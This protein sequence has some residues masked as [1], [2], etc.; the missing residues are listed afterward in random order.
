M[1]RPLLVALLA[2]FAASLPAGA[3][4][5]PASGTLQAAVTAGFD[6][7]LSNADGTPV[8]HLDPGSYVINVDDSTN[9]HNF[10]LNGPGLNMSTTVGEVVMTQWT[11]ELKDGTY[12]FQCD[13]HPG[14]MRGAFTVGTP[15][16]VPRLNAK[17]TAR[18]ISLKD[19]A[20]VRVRTLPQ[21]TYKIAVSDTAK[22]QNFHLSGP[23]VNR[24]TKV[25]ARTKTTW[26]VTLRPGTYVYR[27]DKNRKL[28]RAFIVSSGPPP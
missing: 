4:S 18:A 21:N 14:T 7:S 5:S 9:A 3:S 17:V 16:V 19:A 10:H 24:K 11:V 2:A 23:G 28:R 15:P 26:T 13:A 12:S 8:T 1:V 20:G 25:A 6:I 22:T 27:S